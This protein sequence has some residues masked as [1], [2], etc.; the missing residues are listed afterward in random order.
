MVPLE[1]PV[2]RELGLVTDALRDL[3]QPELGLEQE[4][5]RALEPPPREVTER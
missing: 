3:G 5:G 2:E 4:L 1:G